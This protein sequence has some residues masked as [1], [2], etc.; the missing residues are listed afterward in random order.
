MWT[1]FAWP[2]LCVVIIAG[3]DIDFQIEP[4]QSSPGLYYQ[5]VGTARL[6]SSEWK[7]VTYLSLKVASDNVDEIRKYIDFTAAFCVKHSN[8]WQPNPTICNSILDT[9]KREYEKV[10]EMRSLVLQLTRTER[11]TSRQLKGIFNLVGHVAHSLFGMLDSDSET[12]YNQKISQLEKEQLDWLKLMREQTIVVRSTLKSVNQTLHSV[13]TNELALTKELHKILNFINV[14]NHKIANRYAFT[15]LLFALNDHAMR[16]RQAIEEVK[17]AYNIIIEVCLHWRNEIIQPQMLPPRRLIQIL[18]ISQDNFP[19]VLEVPVVLSEAYSHVLFDIVKV[20]VYLVEDNLVYSIQVPLVVHPVFNVFR[21]IPFPTQVEGVEGRFTLIQPE[22]ELIVHDNVKGF[23]AKLEQTDIRQCKRT[24]V[25]ELICKQDFPLFSTHASTDCEVLMLQPIRL[26]PQSCT[27]RT[28]D[29]KETFWISVRENAWIYV[30]PVPERITVLCVG[31]KPTDVEIKGSG[32]FTFLS[33]CTGYGNT[34]MIRS[35]TIHSINNTG[36]DINQPL[37]LTHD[38]CEMNVDAPPLGELQL[39]IPIKG[40]PTHDGDLHL[41]NHK[42]EKVQKL[43]DEQEW[44]VTHT[45]EKSM[46]L[47]SMIGTMI[48]VVSFCLLCCCCCLCRCCRNCWVRI[49]RWWYFDDNTCKT[50]VFRPKIINS[51]STTNDGYRR[52]LAVSLLNRVHAEQEG[53]GEPTE[54]R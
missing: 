28:V 24:H 7:V 50:I 31:Q 8:L 27:Q 23:Y 33:D 43:V 41:A 29:V 16:V 52:G 1:I 46:S 19:R 37:N 47:L 15:T 36:K 4:V 21:V 12:F 40:I 9:V 35:L 14:G 34:V 2:L 49:M 48:S 11:G 18:K 45:A 3:Q 5:P 13:S 44:K 20:D 22:K 32:V 26:V 53:Q 6:Y 38:C 51:V 25:K 42:V 10:Q 30:A 39:E 54:L 17:D